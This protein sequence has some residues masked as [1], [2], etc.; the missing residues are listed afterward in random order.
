MV[1]MDQCG[2]RHGAGDGGLFDKAAE[3]EA[4]TS[5]RPSV[6][7]EREF[8]QVGLEVFRRHGSLVSAEDPSLEQTGDSMDTGIEARN[9]GPHGGRGVH[10]GVGHRWQYSNLQCRQHSFV[11]PSAVQ[12]SCFSGRDQTDLSTK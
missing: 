10:S 11:A 3:H 8:L 4:T 9:P 1:A 5:R 6:E 7:A 2:L 12:G